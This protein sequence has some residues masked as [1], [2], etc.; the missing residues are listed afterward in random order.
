MPLHRLLRLS[1]TAVL[2]LWHRTET[3]AALGA[4]LPAAA[5][6]AY[7]PL[8][9]TA[10]PERRAQ[11]LAG[12]VLAHA[13]AADLWPGAPGPLVRNE[14]ATGRPY[15]VGPGLPVRA[16]VSLSHSGAWAAA[17][18]TAGS[19]AGVDVE[20]VRDKARCIAPK[21]LAANELAAARA[22]PATA[23]DAHFTLLWSAKETLYKLAARR[24]LIFKEQLL[25]EPIAGPRG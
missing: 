19:R 25:L 21:F 12:R 6:A 4:L 14:P 9:P 2:G 13:V 18:L 11:W 8:L 23:A 7:A 1:P 3:A 20:V 24:G 10:G 5:G 15:L 22:V 17:L 16:V